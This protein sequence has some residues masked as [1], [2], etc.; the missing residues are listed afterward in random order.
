MGPRK[1]TDSWTFENKQ[2]FLKVSTSCVE[3]ARRKKETQISVPL[4]SS[5]M[6]W[7][8]VFPHSSY[9]EILSPNV[10]ISG[11]G[12]FGRWLG[13]EGGALMN[14]TSALIKRPQRAPLPLLLGESTARRP[15]WTRNRVL[16][17]TQ[18]CWDPNLPRIVRNKFLFLW[19]TLSTI[20]CYSR[21]NG[22]LAP[23]ISKYLFSNNIVQT[24]TIKGMKKRLGAAD[25][26]WNGPCVHALDN[27][28]HLHVEGTCDL[29]LISRIRRWWWA[30]IPVMTLCYRRFFLRWLQW[31]ILLARLIE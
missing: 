1:N 20:N 29:L 22:T 3:V 12:A 18:S 24:M 13:H 2:I 10:M 4:M 16:T 11:G 19:A 14:G 6:D 27:L 5:S 17:R 28:H 21:S 30:R 15:L 9:V 23:S 25:R 26:P 31:E 8:F 7:M